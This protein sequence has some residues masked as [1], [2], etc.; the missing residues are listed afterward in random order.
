M[1]AAWWSPWLA[2]RLEDG[3]TDGRRPMAPRASV[4]MGCTGGKWGG[5]ANGG[6]G[7]CLDQR[8]IGMRRRSGVEE[9]VRRVTRG[10]VW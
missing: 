3:G 2:E 1:G 8:L 6:A 5:G 4:Q 10:G 9:G 7:G